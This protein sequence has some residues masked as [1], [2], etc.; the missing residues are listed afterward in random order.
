MMTFDVHFSDVQ[1][2]LRDLEGLP[3]ECRGAMWQAVKRSLTTLRRELAK[4]IAEE[5]Y[6]QKSRITKAI[7][8]VEMYGSKTAGGSKTTDTSHIMGWIRVSSRQLPLDAFK[9]IPNRPTFPKGKS[10]SDKGLSGYKIG[11]KQPVRCREKTAGRS[12]GFVIRG[13]KS[14]KLRFM[15]EVLG[16][17]HRVDGKV[18]PELARVPGYSVQYFAFFDSVYQDIEKQ[19]K[20]R[21]IDVLNHEIQFRLDRIGKGK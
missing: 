21:F 11:P 12:A 3:K 6:L 7:T 13:G 1:F 14:G 15:V 10:R 8:P 20:R 18:R 5:S 16:K 17:R 4:N 9:L 2:L 19:A